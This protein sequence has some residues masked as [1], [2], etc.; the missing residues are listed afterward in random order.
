VFLDPPSRRDLLGELPLVSV[1]V[2]ATG[3]PETLGPLEDLV[4]TSRYRTPRWR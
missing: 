2:L 4:T 3:R 1:A